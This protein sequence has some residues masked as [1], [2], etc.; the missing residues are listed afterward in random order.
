VSQIFAP[1]P[2]LLPYVYPR[3]EPEL[4]V[5]CPGDV[6][7]TDIPPGVVVVPDSNELLNVLFELIFI[8]Y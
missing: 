2:V 3:C 8:F 7:E 5:T 6:D 1:G 4:V